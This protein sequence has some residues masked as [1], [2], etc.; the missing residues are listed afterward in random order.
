MSYLLPKLVR[1][2]EVDKA[3]RNTFDKVRCPEGGVLSG[4]M[5]G[6]TAQLLAVELV[7][8]FAYPS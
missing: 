3:I 1:K 5:S 2:A 6:T 4:K 7:L 8:L